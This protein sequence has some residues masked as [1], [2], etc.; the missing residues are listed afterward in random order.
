M[1]E[2]GRGA[3]GSACPRLAVKERPDEE[4]FRHA[5]HL[6][7]DVGRRIVG[8]HVVGHLDRRAAQSR[9]LKPRIDS[10]DTPPVAVRSNL[11]VMASGTVADWSTA[12]TVLLVTREPGRRAELTDIVARGGSLPMAVNSAQEAIREL[13][14]V[15]PHLV[16]IDVPSAEDSDWALELISRIRSCRGGG[17]VP[18]VVVSV[19][20]CP[21]LSVAALER[22]ADDVVSGELHPDEL[23]ARLRTRI[24]RPSVSRHALALDPV[25]GA[26][27]PAS[28]GRRVRS[29]LER[30]AHGGRPS[31]LALVQLDELP[32]VEGGRAHDE[33]VAQVVALIKRD[34]RTIDHVGHM[35]GV[36]ALLMPATT[37]HGAHV[38]LERLAHLLASTNV[39]VAGE[40]MSMTP[41]IGY[42]SL[43][44]GLAQESLEERAWIAMLH[45]AQQLDL[46]P[47]AWS[48]SMS[49]TSPKSSI[50]VSGLRRLLTPLQIVAQQMACLL[51]P[52][53]AYWALDRI[54]LD[55]S[56]VA[57]LF[58]V[59]V[60]GITALAISMEGLAALRRPRLPDEPAVLPPATAV[61]AAYLPNEAETVLETVEAFLAPGLPG[62]SQIILAYNTPYPLPVED[63]LLEIARA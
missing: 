34:S 11:P 21:R 37:A 32:E 12:T 2:V 31:V 8:S 26:L 43:A 41:I 17:S 22:M 54:G 47:S 59:I 45:Q 14:L 4:A 18:V 10:V 35:R 13:S 60:L 3:R 38:R 6:R 33:V 49:P 50:F 57:Y 53:A 30:L 29:E 58:L 15:L 9:P 42:A 1:L 27:T 36:F 44:R 61:I 24:D 7:V 62:T 52:L 40:P 5:A 46:H 23:V 39:T 51:L 63:E 55:V 48:R 16:V 25:S 56:G 19:Q 20:S 28:F